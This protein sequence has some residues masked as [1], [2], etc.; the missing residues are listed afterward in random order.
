MQIILRYFEFVPILK[1]GIFSK[2]GLK[3]IFRPLNVI[4]INFKS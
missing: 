1:K 3:K 2:V 4:D